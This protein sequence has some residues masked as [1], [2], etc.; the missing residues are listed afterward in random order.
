MAKLTNFVDCSR[1]KNVHA[2]VTN[3]FIFIQTLQGLKLLKFSFLT[4]VLD[5]D[6]SLLTKITYKQ[7]MLNEKQVSSNTYLLMTKCN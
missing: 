4:A 6:C 3:N 2:A 7:H 1:N 5:A